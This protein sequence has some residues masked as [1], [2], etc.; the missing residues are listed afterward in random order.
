MLK[1][2]WEDVR[3]LLV[4]EH[5]TWDRHVLTAPICIAFNV[6]VSPKSFA[7]EQ[8]ILGKDAILFSSLFCWYKGN[9]NSN[10]F[11]NYLQYTKWTVGCLVEHV[12]C[13]RCCKCGVLILASCVSEVFLLLLLFYFVFLFLRIELRQP[14]E[15]RFHCQRQIWPKLINRKSLTTQIKVVAVFMLLEKILE[16]KIQRCD[17]SNESWRWVNS[18]AT[19]CV[20]FWGDFIFLPCFN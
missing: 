8:K 12:C 7:R 13:V 9:I 5:I 20:I 3:L 2:P 19:V 10:A 18:N 17:H 14:M 11:E 16:N 1:N 4:K 6:E 15:S